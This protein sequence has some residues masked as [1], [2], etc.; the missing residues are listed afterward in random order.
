MET[1]CNSVNNTFYS[2]DTLRY[3]Y[4]SIFQGYA[5]IFTLGS[6]FYIYFSGKVDGLR[7]EMEMNA[8]NLVKISGFYPDTNFQEKLFIETV[9]VFKYMEKYII[10][11]KED[12]QTYPAYTYLSATYDIN[13]VKEGTTTRIKSIL[14][15]IVNL[16]IPILLLSLICLYFIDF[17]SSCIANEIIFYSGIVFLIASVLYFI[18]L[19]KLI[20]YC[21][22][23]FHKSIK[24]K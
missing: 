2:V 1:I 20:Y 12:L 10:P 23:M 9:G 8:L 19:G 24:E 18:L 13:I 21:V 6:M 17:K 14:K 5:A 16:S 15:F 11:R 7:R 22:E 3:F 4:S